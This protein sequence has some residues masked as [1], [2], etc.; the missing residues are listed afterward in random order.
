[1]NK[2]YKAVIE[3]SNGKWVKYSDMLRDLGLKGKISNTLNQLAGRRD[4]CCELMTSSDGTVT[5]YRA[6]MTTQSS[7]IDLARYRKSLGPTGAPE[8]FIFGGAA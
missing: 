4:V 2:Q 6:Y 8:S 7:F 3:Y 5:R 1:M